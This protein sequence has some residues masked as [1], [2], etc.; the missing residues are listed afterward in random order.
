MSIRNR[1]ILVLLLMVIVPTLISVFG[2]TAQMQNLATRSNQ[3]I[4]EEFAKATIRDK[5]NDTAQ[6]IQS[7]LR[8][9]PEID[10][11]D[12]AA[13][14][15]NQN[16]GILA[17]QPVGQT[18]YT[19]V[20]DSQGVTHFHADPNVV[21]MDMS[22]LADTLP[23]FWSIFAASLDGSPAEGYYD[24]QD[25]DGSVR[26]KFMAIAPVGDTSLRVAA[27]TY[28][29]EFTRP[30]ETMTAE[31]ER[32]TGLSRLYFSLFAAAMGLIALGVAIYVGVRFTTPLQKMAMAADRVMQGEWDA[33]R[34]S[35]RQDELGNL[36]H[37]IHS[38]TLR[39][40]SLVRGLEQEVAERTAD[41]E[42]RT[43][44]LETTTGIAREATSVLDPEK[45]LS[46][47][48][49]L[50]SERFGFYH[51]GIF[52]VEPTGEWA[53]LRAASS[54]G[55]RRML[56]RGHRLRVGGESIVGRATSQGEPRIAF[57]VGAGAVSFDDPNLP[58][59]RSEMALP[60]RARGE[61]I[62]ALDVHS[63]QS[64]AFNDENVAM[65]QAL[66]D[67]VAMAI[68][69][70]WLF[71]QVQESLEAERRAY[72]DLSR[73]AWNELLRVQSDIG[74]LR[75]KHGILPADGLWRTE[76]KTALQ[77]GK[78]TLAEDGSTGLAAPIKV[79]GHVIGLLD[80]HKP[81]DAGE[82][83]TEEIALLETLTEQLSVALES[84]R[85]YQATQRRA[86]RERL[87]REI[88]DN[89]RAAITVEDAVQ[90]MVSEM[91]RVLGASDMIA[92]IGTEQDLLSGLSKEG[93]EHE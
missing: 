38:M 71:Q 74:V 72:G 62:G 81:Q 82:W 85:L 21:G 76:M 93:D 92:R 39:L 49:T 26:R 10:L 47:I 19:A 5:A 53:A 50:V 34:P 11:S 56:A 40:Q 88:T 23:E 63:T 68:S 91:G 31:L 87:T 57:D 45:L 25:P 9:H 75:D 14:E 3:A 58:D 73:Q 86:A 59:T 29:D 65:L 42:L 4:L 7:Y 77:T 46:Q 1:L 69:N 44:Y 30:V 67:Q 2:A 24:W 90:R 60:L 70:A 20:F 54:E 79:R 52:L 6:Q 41:L 61:I 66:A 48:A 83:T 13:L 36:N 43:R 15:T 28:V 27:T 35:K 51:T 64:E 84:A 37:A 8:L 80:A 78:T 89:I 55:G 12:I 33:I 18:G 17:V 22:T 16:I 32:M